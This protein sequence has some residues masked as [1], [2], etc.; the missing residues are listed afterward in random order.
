MNVASRD[1]LRK[2]KPTV[3]RDRR[4]RR[5]PRHRRDA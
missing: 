5:D 3:A 1:V 4:D 2:A